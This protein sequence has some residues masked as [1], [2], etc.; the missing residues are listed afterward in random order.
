MTP[1][2]SGNGSVKEINSLELSGRCLPRQTQ[3]HWL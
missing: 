2:V 3:S 1:L